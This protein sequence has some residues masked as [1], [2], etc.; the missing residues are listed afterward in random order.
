[1]KQC[2][3]FLAPSWRPWPLAP[4]AAAR[5]TAAPPA[6]GHSCIAPRSSSPPACCLQWH[7]HIQIARYPLGP[8]QGGCRWQLVTVC[9]TGIWIAVRSSSRRTGLLDTPTRQPRGQL[10]GGTRCMHQRHVCHL[11]NQRL[12]PRAACECCCGGTL[13][14]LGRRTTTVVTST[15]IACTPC[16]K[17]LTNPFAL[18]QIGT[19]SH[20]NISEVRS[21]D[22]PATLPK[23]ASAA[24]SQHLTAAW[25]P[26]RLCVP[27]A[28]HSQA[29][30]A[31]PA[32]RQ[33]TP[34][35]GFTTLLQR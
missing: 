17:M 18:M 35:T 15:I 28:R 31:Q 33:H 21:L 22:A 19:C 30:L 11:H 24:Q 1:M 16:H 2:C 13:L 26:S 6:A 7:V 20:V 14:D 23:G 29:L 4:P 10:R 5:R 8:R 34:S 3:R 32:R 12:Q 9:C 25:Q 27:P